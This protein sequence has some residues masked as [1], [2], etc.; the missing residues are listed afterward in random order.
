[1]MVLQLQFTRMV[2]K[3]MMARGLQQCSLR[4]IS[5]KLPETSSVL[6]TELRLILSAITFLIRLPQQEFIVY[7][8]S[9]SALQFICNSFCLHPVVRKIHG[10]LR[11]LNNISLPARDYYARFSTA[12]CRRWHLSWQNAGPN[13]LRFITNS[14]PMSGTS[15]RTNRYSE[16]R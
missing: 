8:D 5:G 9:Q 7:S 11:V 1:M 6:T 14:I 2:P 4:T 10:W 3:E 16:L 15:C 13:K 12:L